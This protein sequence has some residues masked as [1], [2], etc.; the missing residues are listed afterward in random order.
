MARLPDYAEDNSAS[1][2]LWSYFTRAGGEKTVMPQ[3]VSVRLQRTVEQRFLT[4]NSRR[5]SGEVVC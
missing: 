1:T 2:T 3:R 4:S 5:D